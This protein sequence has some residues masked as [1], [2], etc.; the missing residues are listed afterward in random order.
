MHNIEGNEFI[1]DSIVFN[2]SKILNKVIFLTT[3]KMFSYFWTIKTVSWY[4]MRRIQLIFVNQIFE[5]IHQWQQDAVIHVTMLSSYQSTKYLESYWKQFPEYISTIKDIL[6]RVAKNN[7]NTSSKAFSLRI[8][9]EK[10]FLL[11]IHDRLE[12]AILIS[13]IR[14]EHKF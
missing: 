14:F 1:S 5:A 7:W 12:V 4:Q 3:L 9:K 10:N 6:I 13:D 11:C 2:I 8:F